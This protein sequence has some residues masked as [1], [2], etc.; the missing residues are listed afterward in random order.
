MLMVRFFFSLTS[1]FISIFFFFFCTVVDNR[2]GLL[3]Q[4][5]SELQWTSVHKTVWLSHDGTA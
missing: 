5:Q 4:L 1:C 3:S 2:D